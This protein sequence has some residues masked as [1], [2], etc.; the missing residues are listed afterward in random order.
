[1]ISKV[2]SS[3][4]KQ[5]FTSI[6]VEGGAFADGFR[7]DLPSRMSALIGPTGSGKTTILELLAFAAQPPSHAASAH[8]R[9]N[10][11]TGTL[12]AHVVAANQR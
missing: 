7:L 4:P 6:T 1:M 8:V 5:W 3:S 11:G 2:D 12:V 9:T 10:L